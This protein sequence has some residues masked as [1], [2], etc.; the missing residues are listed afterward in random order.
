MTNNK[1]NVLLIGGGGREYA[2]AWKISQ[3]QLLSEFYSINGSDHIAKYAN[4]IDIDY[5]DF[6]TL[7]KF[8]V[9]KNIHLVIVGPEKP[10]ELGLSDFL[11]SKKINVF[12]PSKAA[13]QIESSKHFTKKICDEEGI[14]T[15]KYITFQNF[16]DAQD[17]IKNN[18]T[19]SYPFVIKY[20]GLADGKGVKIIHDDYEALE[21]LQK[22]NENYEK[23]FCVVIEEFLTG[24]ELSAFFLCDGENIRYLASA[25]DYKRAHDGDKG[26]N[27]GG[28][29]VICGNFLMNE[30]LK[31]KISDR[32]VK[33][34]LHNLKKQNIVY[35]GVIFAGL[36]IDEKN[37]P[38]LIE[39]NARFGDPETEAIC[40]RLESD[41]LNI[42]YKTTI[43]DL[44]NTEIKISEKNSLC[45]VLASNG[46]PEKYE[47][48]KLIH[49]I[50][51]D[52]NDMRIFFHGAK[53]IHNDCFSNGGRVL[54]VNTIGEN[55]DLMREQAYNTLKEIN[56]NDGFYRN[57]I[58]L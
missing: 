51:E 58:G 8:C 23:T 36:M 40:M 28:M 45:I 24:R 19:F 7:Y 15:A 44:Q 46:Y 25:R 16:S 3:S 47:K 20:D 32:I 5:S 49:N 34:M 27:T 21:Y 54:S 33:P 41:L 38:Y 11:I 35:K 31:H 30:E 29:G 57:D 1:L 48:G 12:A 4:R 50:P 55:I 43:G 39:F 6:E 2:L 14:P 22:L 18:K 9:E 10:I 42:L 13:A 37:D 52:T 17:F 26:E 56:W 53:I